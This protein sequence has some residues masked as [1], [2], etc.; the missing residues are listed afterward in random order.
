MA[1]VVTF[2]TVLCQPGAIEALCQ[3]QA[4]H[5]PTESGQPLSKSGLDNALPEWKK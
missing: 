3:P 5:R 1:E 4:E 2:R